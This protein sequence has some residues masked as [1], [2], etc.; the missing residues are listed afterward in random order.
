TATATAGIEGNMPWKKDGEKWH[1]S[2]KGF[3]LGKGVKWDRTVLPKMLK[4][5]R[6]VDPTL[7]FKWDV[8][9]A[10][11]VRPLGSSRFWC[12][13][14]TKESAALEVW[15]VGQRG[16]VNLGR[17]E[18]IGRESVIE[19]DR[20]DGSEVLKLWFVT[21]DNLPAGKVKPVLVEHLRGFLKAFGDSAEKEAG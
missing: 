15:F 3:P 9:D 21:G 13:I 6:E 20:D 2:D 17:L 7:E 12:R 18:G 14:K 10:V 4:L 1:L 19:G 8:R 16:Q 11:T 5:L